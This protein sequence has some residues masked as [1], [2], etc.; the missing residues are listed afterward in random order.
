MPGS[1]TAPGLQGT[2]DRA[3]FHIAFRQENGVG[4]R[5]QVSFAAQWLACA[6]PYRR[7]ADVLTNACA[8]LGA[9]V[10]RYSLIAVDLHHLLLAG[11]PAHL[12][13]F[14]IHKEMQDDCN[15]RR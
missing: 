5:D 13:L 12:T 14:S 11:L 9:N 8:R 4:T 6:Y 7:F 2:C 3:P 1:P 10:D 15:H